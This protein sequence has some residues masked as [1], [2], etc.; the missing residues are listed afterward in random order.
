MP[1]E[2]AAGPRARISRGENTSMKLGLLYRQGD[3]IGEAS[4]AELA[5][6]CARLGASIICPKAADGDSWEGEFDTDPVLKIVDADALS[7][8]RDAYAAHG[9]SLHPWVVPRG[10]SNAI[11]EASRHA[12]IARICGTVVVDFEYEYPGFFGR[13]RDGTLIFGSGG[14]AMDWARSYFA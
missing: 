11:V 4:T 14:A 12:E 8:Q 5:D 10:L 2:H 1:T 6:L 7:R 3:D 13:R 9:M